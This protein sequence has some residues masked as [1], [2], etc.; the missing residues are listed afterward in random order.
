MLYGY[1]I[2]EIKTIGVGEFWWDEYYEEN[3]YKSIETKIFH[4]L[5]ER[6]SAKKEDEKKY[7]KEITLEKIVIIDFETENII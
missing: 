4:S 6:N 3:E 1:N 7:Y 2:V 5:D